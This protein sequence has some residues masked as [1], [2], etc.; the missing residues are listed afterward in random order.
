MFGGLFPD[1]F[2]P[3]YH[4]HHHYHPALGFLVHLSL[5]CLFYAFF[6]A[7]PAAYGSSQ[8]RGQN[9]TS[10]AGLYHSSQQRR[11][12]NPLSKAKDRTCILMDPSCVRELLSHEGNSLFTGLFFFFF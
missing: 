7:A 2:L 6:R 5:V 9:R 8:A 11:I 1:S 12:L 3:C 4:D 10:A